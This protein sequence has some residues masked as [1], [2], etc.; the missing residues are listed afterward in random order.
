VIENQ[1]GPNALWLLEGLVEQLDIPAGSRVLDL[2]CGHAM[3][4]VFLARE[5]G[6]EVWATDLW[7][8]AEANQQAV[9]KAGVAGLVHPIHAEAHA[10]PFE[11]SFFDLV[12]SVDAYQYFGTDDLY[13]G[14]VVD[15]VKP[16]GRIA[17]VVPA[18]LYEIED[19]P[20]EH[21]ASFWEWDFCAWHSPEWWRRHWAKTGL[22]EIEQ[23]AAVE[24]GW[25]D[26]LQFNDVTLPTSRMPEAAANTRE[27]LLADQGRF[28][29]FTRIVARK[30]E[31]AR[32]GNT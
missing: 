18:G 10:L 31:R 3:S 30:P 26:W 2:G 12:V 20:P 11:A 13:L 23:A 27:M 19:E 22:V 6:A 32:P 7:I 29:G 21:L 14:T 8:S 25:R 24:D 4:S 1:M 9:D 28:L 16:G 17:A 15:L 5:F